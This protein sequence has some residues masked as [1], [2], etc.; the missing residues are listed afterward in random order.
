MLAPAIPILQIGSDIR[1]LRRCSDL[2]REVSGASS[3]IPELKGGEEIRLAAYPV[4]L[5]QL[6]VESRGDRLELVRRVRLAA[7]A[8]R[9]LVL[10]ARPSVREAVEFMKIGGQD[11]LELPLEA[12]ALQKALIAALEVAGGA[13]ERSSAA[14][15]SLAYVDEHTGLP[16]A[17][18][19]SVS[20]DAEFEKLRNT[21][22]CDGASV[23][24]AVLFVDIDDF[25]SVNDRHGHRVGNETLRAVGRFLR[26]QLREGDRLFRY[27]GDEFVALISG[28]D[29]DSAAGVAE[30]LAS[31]VASHEFQVPAEGDVILKL[32]LRVSIGTAVCP[33]HA[34]TREEILEIADRA[35]YCAKRPVRVGLAV[36]LGVAPTPGM[37]TSLNIN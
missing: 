12:E 13:P 9:V 28:G 10:T 25:K 24:F 16:N 4:I 29:M 22:E 17:R 23:R 3:E 20:L 33:D 35:L 37:S 21:P 19:L 15:L 1:L 5:I 7:P 27:A 34:S 18:Y 31:A 32:K 14:S 36:D 8:A 6:D 2:I 11:Y 30:R 26:Q